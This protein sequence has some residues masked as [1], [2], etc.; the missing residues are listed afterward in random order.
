MG[1]LYVR[2]DDRL[3]HGQTIVAWCPTLGIDEIIGVDDI[4]AANPMLK[5]IMTMGVPK[6][7]KTNIVTTAE[8]K[9]LLKKESN[10]N[11]LL[12]VKYPSVLQNLTDYIKNCEQLILGNIA[13]REDTNHK[14]SGA[15]GIFYLSDSD[16]EILDN[17]V[18]EGIDVVF[19]QLPN[20]TKVSWQ[21]FK[22]TI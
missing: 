10:K 9:E 4:S 11:R 7:Y 22:E 19:H 12:I 14:V 17:L 13:K 21:Q 20:T 2:V 18:A 15:T 6:N 16:V 3:I 5:S 1:K 8:A